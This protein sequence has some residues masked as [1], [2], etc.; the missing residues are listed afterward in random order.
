MATGERRLNICTSTLSARN[1]LKSLILTSLQ[2]DIN[3]VFETIQALDD[4]GIDATEFF[5]KA[6]ARAQS[7]RAALG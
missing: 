7:Q 2:V 4:A 5:R 3:L 1:G 6:L